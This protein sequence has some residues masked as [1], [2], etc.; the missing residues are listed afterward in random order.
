MPRELARHTLGVAARAFPDATCHIGRQT[1]KTHPE[2]EWP[3]LGWDMDGAK[4]WR[5]RRE[6]KASTAAL[7]SSSLSVCFCVFLLPP[8]L[9]MTSR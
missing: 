1:Q 4:G 8:S 7:H 6:G 5:K 3:Q 9:L 2:C